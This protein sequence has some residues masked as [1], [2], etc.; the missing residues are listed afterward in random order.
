MRTAWLGD[1]GR[2]K[3]RRGPARW[4]R[5]GLGK[6]LYGVIRSARRLFVSITTETPETTVTIGTCWTETQDA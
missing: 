4:G 6:G 1:G 5:D 3:V 2:G